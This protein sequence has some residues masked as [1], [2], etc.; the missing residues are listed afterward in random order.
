MLKQFILISDGELLENTIH[1]TEHD[2]A[3]ALIAS[4]NAGN[5]GDADEFKELIRE[6]N[7]EAMAA[8]YPEGVSPSVPEPIDRVYGLKDWLASQGYDLYLEDVVLPD[9]GDLS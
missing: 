2:R 5:I 8:E 6:Q 9:R 3:E 4:I 1:L 7:E